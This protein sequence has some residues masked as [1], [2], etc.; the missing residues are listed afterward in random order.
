MSHNDCVSLHSDPAMGAD[1][2]ALLNSM[3][4]ILR[5]DEQNV[6]VTCAVGIVSNVAVN[7]LKSDHPAKW[8]GKTWRAT[9]ALELK[10][11]F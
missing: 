4:N 10:R 5:H 7:S 2:N 11:I 8:N 1:V 6:L 3:S 9:Q